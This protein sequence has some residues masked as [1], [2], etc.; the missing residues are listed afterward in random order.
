MNKPQ[1]LV[2]FTVKVLL[3]WLYGYVF[4]HYYHGD[5]TWKFFQSSIAETQLLLHHPS[6]FFRNEFTPENAMLTGNGAWEVISIYL[7]DLQYV[8]VVK[9]MAVFNLISRGN[10]YINVIFFN[11]IVFFG[12]VWLYQ[13]M[14]AVFPGRKWLYYVIVFFFLPSVFW[15]SG[16]RVD[17]VLFFFLSLL[18]YQAMAKH[19]YSLMRWALMIVAFAGVVICR[20]QVAVLSALMLLAYSVSRKTGRTFASFF[21]VYAL[22][23]V[24][25]FMPLAG[26]TTVVADW[27]HRFLKLEGTKFRLDALDAGSFSYLKV[28]P[29]ALANTFIRPFPWEAKGFLQ[30]MASA[31][32]ALFWIIVI[33]SL[34]RLHPFWRVRLQHPVMMSLLSLG[35]ATFIVIGFMVPF[36]GA[37]I[38]YKAIPELLILCS[39]ASMSAYAETTY[40]KKL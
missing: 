4:L 22:A 25:F 21:W 39:V 26:L 2:G 15:L 12:H 27:Q 11:A 5:D 37:I 13:L 36:P 16:I 8:L 7:N 30:L 29:Q 28:L 32:V 24:L 31:E 34:Y 9:T 1:L 10:Y 14:C 6:L 17:G 33:M 18:L 19:G 40:Y 23:V 20:P 3:G 38:R 35:V